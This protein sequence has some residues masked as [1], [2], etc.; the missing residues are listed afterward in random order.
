MFRQNKNVSGARIGIV[1]AGFIAHV[2]GSAAQSA[3]LSITAVSS[4]TFASA[5]ELAGKLDAHPVQIDAIGE[6]CSHLLITA[7]P[8][9][10]VELAIPFIEMGRRVLIEKPLTNTLEKV[11]ALNVVAN[12]HSERSQVMC[13]ENLLAAPAWTKV[14]ELRPGLGTPTHLSVRVQQQPPEW[15]YFAEPMTSG[16]VVF[17][18]GYHPI[19]LIIDAM[20][21]AP[22][23]VAAQLHSSRLDGADDDAEILLYFSDPDGGPE[24][25]AELNVSWSTSDPEWGLQMASPTSVIRFELLP[26]YVLE[27]NGMPV[28]LP[29]PTKGVDQLM[30]NYG[31]HHQLLSWVRNGSSCQSV[32]DAT[33]TT[34]TIMAIYKSAGLGGKRVSVP[35]NEDRTLTPMQLWNGR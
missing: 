14:R 24:L 10:H 21:R 7:P 12:A 25:A 18:I 13:A 9:F 6:Q 30:W 26:N 5:R 31:Y 34:E 19:A 33:R 28:S 3:G 16:G 20:G 8:E 2:H 23:A 22:D 11:D 4:R 15:G 29:Q 1:G 17:D 32:E 35:M 27:H